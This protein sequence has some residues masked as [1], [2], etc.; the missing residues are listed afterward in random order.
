MPLSHKP[1]EC[2]HKEGNNEHATEQ[3]E[4]TNAKVCLCSR[5]GPES[6]PVNLAMLQE[7]CD[8]GLAGGAGL[9]HLALAQSAAGVCGA[10]LDVTLA[11]QKAGHRFTRC[12]FQQQQHR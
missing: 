3:V 5:Q 4:E 11:L 1:Q 7:L 6:S 12:S 8:V 9:D 2:D 10:V